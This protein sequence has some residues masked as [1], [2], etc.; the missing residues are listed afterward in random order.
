MKPKRISPS[1]FSI[2]GI[3]VLLFSILGCYPDESLTINELDIVATNYDDDYFSRV[4]PQS[5]HLPDTVGVI[6]DGDAQL[7]R[8]AMDFILAQ[9]RRNFNDLGYEEKKSIDENDLPDVVVTVSAVKVTVTGAGCIP[10]Y[11]WWGWYPWYPGWGWGG[12]WCYPTYVYAYETG[13]LAIDMISPEESR[14]ETFKRVWTAG[15]N[16]LTRSDQVGNQE[17]VRSTIDQAF[18]QS[19][20]LQQ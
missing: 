8:A 12:G 10:W 7:D 4:S 5:Y 17:F 20:Y 15:I 11:P 9:V 16:G 2:I 19:P 3:G 6:G 14:N 13:T 1:S 18:T